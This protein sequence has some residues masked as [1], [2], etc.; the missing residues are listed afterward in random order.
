M[1]FEMKNLGEIGCFLG[2][3]VEKSNQGYFVSPKG[4]AKGLLERFGVGESKEMATPMESYLKLKK[5][6]GK[7]LKDAKTFR[8]LVGSLIYLTITRPEISY[9]V[10]WA[11]DTDDRRSTSGYCFNIGSAVISWCSKKQAVFVL[12]SIEAKYVVATM[13]AHECIWLKGL[14]RDMLCKVNYVVQIKCDNENAIK[15][16]SNLVFHA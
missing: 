16:A 4:Y 13:A 1:C 3:Q 6:E 5:D 8:Q 15:L 11:R 10:D 14:I 12:S 7:L 9:S 2:L